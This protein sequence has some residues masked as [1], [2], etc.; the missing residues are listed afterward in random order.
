MLSTSDFVIKYEKY[1][2]EK[3]YEIY[4]D[5][6]GYSTEAL[7][8]LRIVLEKKGGVDALLKRIEQQ[9]IVEKEIQRIKKE[10][11]QLGTNGVDASFIL[12]TTTS[13]ILSA[14]QVKEIVDSKLEEV[15]LELE[16]KKINPR[17]IVGSIVGGAIAS[18]VGGVLWGV[19]IIY[20]HRIFYIFGIGLALLC[21]GIIKGATKQSKNNAV[22][23]IATIISV[24]LALLIGQI[25]FEMIGYKER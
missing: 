4:R 12:K 6:D 7:E 16:D 24:I 5:Q 3:L 11:S 25:L 2:D 18:I 19:Q 21:Y 8:A 14:D 13:T 15:N 9:R 17:T 23:L 22:V 20:V 10:T 1:T